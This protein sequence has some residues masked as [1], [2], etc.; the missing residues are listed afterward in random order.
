MWWS[1][2]PRN[3]HEC[4]YQYS[5]I[6]DVITD[7]IP[8]IGDASDMRTR[9]LRRLFRSTFDPGWFCEI[10]CTSC[11]FACVNKQS[12]NNGVSNDLVRY[13]NG[14][15]FHWPMSFGKFDVLSMGDSIISILTSAH[16]RSTMST[17]SRNLR[18]AL[19]LWFQALLGTEYAIIF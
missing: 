5:R 6:A 19:R 17:R 12:Q 18:F 14:A 2:L 10:D 9:D 1:S 16:D 15:P 3:I 4:I 11:I 13:F 8:V 7:A